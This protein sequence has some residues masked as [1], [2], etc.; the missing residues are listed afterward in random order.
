MLALGIDIGATRIKAGLVDDGGRILKGTS[1]PTPLAP[2]EFERVLRRLAAEVRAGGEAI[3]GVGVGCKG[4]IDAETSRVA[5]LPGTLHFLE[6]RLLCDLAGMPVKA[7][8]DARVAM[9]GE[10]VWGAARGRRNAVMLTL[11]TGV[12]GAVLADGRLLRGLTGAA[13]HLGHVVVDPDGPPCICGNTGCLEALFSAHAIEAAALG[14]VHRGCASTLTERFRA[15]PGELTCRDV[16]EAASEG[17]RQ[18]RRILDRAIRFLGAGI[19]GLI[20]IFDPE[21]V[22]LGGQ[23]SE[24]GAALFDPVREE[25]AWR[26]RAMIGRVVP[27]VAQQVADTSGVAGAAALVFGGV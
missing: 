22:I 26:S 10:M 16:F 5:I 14:V 13:G 15:A 25:T 19:A 18:A 12:G 3:A 20:H 7:D 2:E 1:A 4:V 6:G 21:V 27:I 17:D 9:A 24:A 8:N 23:I 11:G